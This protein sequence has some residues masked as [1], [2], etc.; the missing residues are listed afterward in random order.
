MRSALLLLC[1]AWGLAACAMAVPLRVTL[2]ATSPLLATPINLRQATVDTPRWEISRTTLVLTFTN[3]GTSTLQLNAGDLSSLHVQLEAQG[4]RPT[5]VRCDL[6][7]YKRTSLPET[8]VIT[9]PAGEHWSAEIPFPGAVGELVYTLLDPGAYR[10]R[11]RYTDLSQVTG[12]DPATAECW[13]GIAESDT[14]T[15]KVL[16][17]STENGGQ[18]ALDATADRA[19]QLKQHLP[20][21][22][23]TLAYSGAQDKPFYSLDVGVKP[24]DAGEDCFTRHIHVSEAE[25]AALVDFLAREHYLRDAAP[26]TPDQAAADGYMLTISDGAQT[27][28]QRLDMD[29]TLFPRLK[30]LSRALPASAAPD[31]QLLQ[32]RLSGFRAIWEATAARQRPL[33]LSFAHQP[34]PEAVEAIRAALACP[35]LTIKVQLPENLRPEV[36]MQCSNVPAFILL[37]ELCRSA[38]CAV[39]DKGTTLVVHFLE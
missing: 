16:E 33:T 10:L 6:R 14:L 36:N 13:N 22:H 29:L 18:P 20:D 35:A 39:D 3:T 2:S 26:P 28:R 19:A 9:I 27:W 24:A 31:M 12:Q 7:H 37:E 8:K 4:P 34:L 21:F 23:L 25:A 38:G 11:M 30:A 15:V 5:S 1:V 32:G 17:A